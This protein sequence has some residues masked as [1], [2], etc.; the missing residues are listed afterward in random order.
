[1]FKL[2][3]PLP[4]IRSPLPLGLRFLLSELPLLV[5]KVLPIGTRILPALGMRHNG[6]GLYFRFPTLTVK[7]PRQFREIGAK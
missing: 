6:G 2:F 5:R 1:M 3:L 7:L 4:L